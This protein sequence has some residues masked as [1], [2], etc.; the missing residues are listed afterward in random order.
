MTTPLTSPPAPPTA[1]P[2]SP[3]PAPRPPAPR[4]SA[5]VI[6]ILAIALGSVLI[7]G[8]FA[9]SVLSAIHSTLSQRTGTLT[10]SGDGIR[11]LDVDV[12][13]TRLT[14]VY[15][16]D[17]VRLEVTGDPDAWRLTRDGASLG[18]RTTREWWGGAWRLFAED[19]TA[20]LTLPRAMED[21]RIDADFAVSAGTLQASGRYGA[22]GLDLS[23]ASVDLGGSAQSLDGRLSAGRLAFTLDGVDTADLRMSAGAVTGEITGR[24]PR[25]VSADVSAGRLD[26]TLPDEAYDVRTDASA[27]EIRNDLRVD[28][29]APSQVSV[30]VEAGFARLGS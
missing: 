26:L 2:T 19:D 7:I 3:A 12:A 5:R 15:E 29:S 10:A 23:A 28:R 13:A 17:E 11:A 21:T 18:V 24:A 16:G 20:V 25:T 22:L 9:T 30:S 27:G 14:I 8:A 1:G 6:A 4:S